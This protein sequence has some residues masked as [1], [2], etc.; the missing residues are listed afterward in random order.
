[1]FNKSFYTNRQPTFTSRFAKSIFKG[2]TNK[3]RVISVSIMI[4]FNIR[5]FNYENEEQQ[6]KGG[7][8]INVRS[9]FMI[10]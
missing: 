8:C 2:S 5:F 4:N 9:H 10:I 1:M 7:K 6:G 3:L